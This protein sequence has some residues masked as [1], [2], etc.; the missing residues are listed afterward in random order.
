MHKS[1]TL[2]LHQLIFFTL[3]FVFEKKS[4]NVLQKKISLSKSIN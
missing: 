2:E 3:M 1:T 4:I